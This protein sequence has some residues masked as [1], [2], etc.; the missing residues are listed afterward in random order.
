MNTADRSLA[1]IDLAFRRRFAFADLEPKLGDRW[2]EWVIEKHG[3]DAELAHEV[4]RRITEL[5]Q[6]IAEDDRLGSQ[7][8]IG[9]SFVTPVRRLEA[10]K[11]K[12]WFEQIVKS[13]IGPQLEE[14]WFDDPKTAKDAINRLIERL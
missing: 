11:T 2:R 6:R 5:N 3:V 13:K 10:G 8:R 9:H 7:F 4:E 1:L 12:D 14:Y